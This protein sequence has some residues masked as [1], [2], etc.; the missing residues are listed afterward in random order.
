MN[1]LDQFLAGVLAGARRFAQ[2]AVLQADVPVR[3]LFGLK[4]FPSIATC[5]P[6]RRA[7]LHGAARATL[8]PEPLRSSTT[9]C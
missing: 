4:R 9:S 7:T 3:Q 2:L 5:S 1:D 6:R 8:P